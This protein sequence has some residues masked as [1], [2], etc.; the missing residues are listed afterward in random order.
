MN[1]IERTIIA[2]IMLVAITLLVAIHY[3][4]ANLAI[5][6][7]LYGTVLG[8]AFGNRNG[9]KALAGA[10]LQ[11]QA[12]ATSPT[13]PV[14]SEAFNVASTTVTGNDSMKVGDDPK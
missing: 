2:G 8:Y 3:S 6:A 10:I 9:E 1:S 7:G 4:D 5:A 12:N 13:A 14:D 11:A